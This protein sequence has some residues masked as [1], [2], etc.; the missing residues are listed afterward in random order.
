MDLINYKGL[1][2]SSASNLPENERDRLRVAGKELVIGKDYDRI[3]VTYPSSTVEEY[4]YSLSSS[5]VVSIR[6]TYLTASKR[7]ISIVE[8]I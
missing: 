8:V 3:D 6:V 5:P 2:Q 4:A 7:D 1:Y